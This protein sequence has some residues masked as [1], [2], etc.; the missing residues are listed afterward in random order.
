[1]RILNWVWIIFYAVCLVFTVGRGRGRDVC[2]CFLNF[3]QTYQNLEQEKKLNEE[4]ALQTLKKSGL[5]NFL[6]NF[7]IYR[8]TN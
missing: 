5:H 6:G 3:R 2:D 4:A 1:M 7:A 8:E